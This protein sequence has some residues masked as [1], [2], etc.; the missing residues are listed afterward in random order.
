MA[1]DMDVMVEYTSKV[2]PFMDTAETIQDTSAARD[3]VTKLLQEVEQCMLDDTSDAGG[4]SSTKRRNAFLYLRHIF[5]TLL[6]HSPRD[7]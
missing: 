7:K 4:A 5:R 6:G 3:A 2:A 1:C